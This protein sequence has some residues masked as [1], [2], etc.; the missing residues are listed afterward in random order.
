MVPIGRGRASSSSAIA[1]P[2]TA[3]AID[4]ILN[5]KDTGVICIYIDQP[6]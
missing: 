3:V 2:E 4:A 5:Q 1:R 6:E